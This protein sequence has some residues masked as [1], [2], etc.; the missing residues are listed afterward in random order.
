MRTIN[1]NIFWTSRKYKPNIQNI[2]FAET[3][4]HG[5]THFRVAQNP[6]TMRIIRLS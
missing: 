5:L 3:I 4:R 1:A 6:G 2:D